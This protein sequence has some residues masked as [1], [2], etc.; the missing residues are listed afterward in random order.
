MNFGGNP[1]AACVR[2]CVPGDEHVEQHGGADGE[3][4]EFTD[5]RQHERRSVSCF[6]HKHTHTAQRQR[7]VLA[8]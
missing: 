3:P 2:A 4:S 6:P 7:A 8:S 5:L 1:A